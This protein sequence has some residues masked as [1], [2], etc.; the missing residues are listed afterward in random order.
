MAAL[1]L[2]DH[3]KLG[4]FGQVQ[5]SF[6][7]SDGGVSPHSDHEAYDDPVVTA[8][9]LSTTAMQFENGGSTFELLLDPGS[10]PVLPEIHKQSSDMASK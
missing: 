1:P 2:P 4:S 5:V 10:L 3:L 9:N 7:E 8:S 6:Y